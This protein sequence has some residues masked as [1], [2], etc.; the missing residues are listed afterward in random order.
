[1]AHLNATTIIGTIAVVIAVYGLE[2]IAGGDR[3]TV[4][5][6]ATAIAAVIGTSAFYRELNR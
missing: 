2:M 3:W 5:V 4:T 1:M 6:V